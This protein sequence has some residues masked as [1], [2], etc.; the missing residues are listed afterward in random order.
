[1][2]QNEPPGT[3][4][5]RRATQNYDRN[6]RNCLQKNLAT[7]ELNIVRFISKCDTD[8]TIWQVAAERGN[9]EL[10]EKV[11]EGGKNGTDI[12]KINF[13]LPGVRNGYLPQGLS[14]NLR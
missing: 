12:S 5:Q 7:E 10:L 9:S 3:W 8:Q 2:I 14:K 13:C 4:R 11:L 6:Y 1:M